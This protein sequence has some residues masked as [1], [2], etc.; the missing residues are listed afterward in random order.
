MRVGGSARAPI[1]NM[2]ESRG[3]ELASRVHLP[4]TDGAMAGEPICVSHVRIERIA[5][6]LRPAYLPA[7]VELDRFGM[8]RPSVAHY[9][10]QGMVAEPHAPHKVHRSGCGRL[11]PC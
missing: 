4:A 9:S 1:Y 8:H 7:K 3:L 6:P 5:S 11:T 10:I 2:L